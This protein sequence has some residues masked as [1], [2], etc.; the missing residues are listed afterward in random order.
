ML[1]RD[2]QIQTQTHQLADACLVALSFWAAYLLRA[3]ANLSVWLR[4]EPIP[5][6]AFSNINTL[7]LAFALIPITP[8]ILE[9]QGFY[10]RQIL[11]PRS[12]ILWPL[13]K[14][15]CWW[16][17]PCTSTCRAGFRSCSASSVSR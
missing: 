3:D 17:T 2:H 12:D 8:L 10:K 1:R 15:W 14:G 11:G 7:L 16:D 4:F 13:L 5:P 6:D 9:S